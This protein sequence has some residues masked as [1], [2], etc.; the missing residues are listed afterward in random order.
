MN[1]EALCPTLSSCRLSGLVALNQDGEDE[2]QSSQ[3]MRR[4]CGVTPQKSISVYLTIFL[5]VLLSVCYPSVCLW[6]CYLFS[7]T[8]ADQCTASWGYF[9]TLS[10]STWARCSSVAHLKYLWCAAETSSTLQSPNLASVCLCHSVPLSQLFQGHSNTHNGA[11]F[12]S[13]LM[14]RSEQEAQKLR[15]STY[16]SV[17]L[18]SDPPLWSAAWQMGCVAGGRWPF[19]T[20]GSWARVVPEATP[21]LGQDFWA[22]QSGD[23]WWR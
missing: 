3:K 19:N 5:S 14:R 13:W 22:G 17:S 9:R 4:K 15:V 20:V 1:L 8:S 21:D 2:S 23:A 16:F 12:I 18:L 7:S 6:M 10:C 11:S